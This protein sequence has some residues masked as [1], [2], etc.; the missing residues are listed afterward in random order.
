MTSAWLAL[1]ELAFLARRALNLAFLSSSVEDVEVEDGS[2]VDVEAVAE[3][4]IL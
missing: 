4:V 2:V 3:E 1:V